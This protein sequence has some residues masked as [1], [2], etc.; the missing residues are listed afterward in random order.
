[1]LTIAICDDDTNDTLRI[2]ALVKNYMD[3]RKIS[4]QVNTFPSGEELLRIHKNFDL[5][6]LDIGLNGING[7]LVG[8]KIRERDHN[9]KVIYTTSFHQF[10]KQA[11]NHVHAFAYLVKPV[12]KVNTEKQLDDIL[13]YIQEEHEPSETVRFEILEITQQGEV[14]TRIKDFEV[15]DIFYFEYFNRKIKIK[16]EN[17]EYF[18]RDKMKDLAEKMLEHHFEV[19]HQCFLVNLRHVKKIKGYEAYLNNNDIIPVSQK[20][21]A[22]FRKKLNQFILSNI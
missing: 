22:A 5:I 16:L 15:K 13:Q 10:C 14:E 11:V 8:K 12:T 4:Y 1:M 9:V 19:C 2:A 7:I 17:K 21:S 6:F 20:K 3:A 18:F